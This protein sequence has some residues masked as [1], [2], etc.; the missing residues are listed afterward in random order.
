M[1]QAKL[2]ASQL[3][4]VRA[5][6]AILAMLAIFTKEP[7]GTLRQVSFDL[8]RTRSESGSPALARIRLQG[9]VWC[10][11]NGRLTAVEAI[12]ELMEAGALWWELQNA[13]VV[14]GNKHFAIWDVQIFDDGRRF[15]G[16]IEQQSISRFP[17]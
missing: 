2:S 5:I 4:A 9:N 3:E 8:V 11:H 7:I 15:D 6:D 1:N 12:L 17:F 16:K 14:I 10:G 13:N